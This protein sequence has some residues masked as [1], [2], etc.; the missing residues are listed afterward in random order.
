[1]NFTLF[2][3]VTSP[4]DLLVNCEASKTVTLDEYK[5]NK[6]G[7]TLNKNIIMPFGKRKQ[8][9]KNNK[10]YK[11]QDICVHFSDCFGF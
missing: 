1:M 5:V 6:K 2:L 7:L 8:K 3:Y 11:P 9:T 4:I 10:Q